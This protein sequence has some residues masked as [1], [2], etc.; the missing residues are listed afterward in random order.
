MFGVYRRGSGDREARR[1][2]GDGE[3]RGKRRVERRR[4]YQRR[5]I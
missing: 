1:G 5:R 3:R 4:I 2:G